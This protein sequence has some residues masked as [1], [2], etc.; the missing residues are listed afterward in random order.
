MATVRS[1]APEPESGLLSNNASNH[2]GKT[3]VIIPTVTAS[4]ARTT[5]IQAR[6]RIILVLLSRRPGATIPPGPRRVQR[7][8]VSLAPATI[9]G[10]RHALRTRDRA[11]PSAHCLVANTG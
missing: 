1:K 11:D 9:D 10:V 4:A 7:T 5:S 6:M 2:V 8:I 3:A